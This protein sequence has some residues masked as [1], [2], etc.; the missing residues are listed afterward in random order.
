MYLGYCLCLFKLQ[1]THSLLP[2][3][4]SKPQTLQY[5]FFIHRYVYRIP[6]LALG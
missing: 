4:L 5:N 6:S 2:G 1:S 3:F